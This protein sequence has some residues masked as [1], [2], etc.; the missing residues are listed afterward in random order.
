MRRIFL[1]S[2]AMVAGCQNLVG[3]LGHRDA[4]RPD[5]PTLTIGE[6]QRRGRDLLALPESSTTVAPP[7]YVDRP[8]VHG[9]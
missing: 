7:T 3:P 4:P 6:Q 9:R 8:G 2:F 5:D 1:L